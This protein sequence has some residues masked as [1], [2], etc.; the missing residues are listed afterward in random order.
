MTYVQSASGSHNASATVAVAYGSNVTAGNKLIALVTSDANAVGLT[1]TVKDGAGNTMTQIALP[2]VAGT[3]S[4]GLFAMDVPAGDAGG[5]PTITATASTSGD[6]SMLLEE[7]S[8]LN[9]GNTLAAMIDGTAGTATGNVSPTTS[10]AYS[11]TV[12]GEYLVC[13]FGDNLFSN[14]YTSPAGYTAD[15]NNVTSASFCHVAIAHKNSAGGAETGSY[16][17]TGAANYGVVLAAFKL[18]PAVAAAVPAAGGGKSML[19]RRLALADL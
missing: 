17:Y 1:Y 6:M 8:G 13:C 18:A 10:P 7:V 14:T 15:P 19:A 3:V 11:T 5:T 2:E 4:V 16:S 9:P 12:T